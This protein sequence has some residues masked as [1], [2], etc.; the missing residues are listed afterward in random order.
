MTR[1]LLSLLVRKL[2]V[3]SLVPTRNRLV[4]ALT[5]IRKVPRT[6]LFTLAPTVMVLVP[7]VRPIVLVKVT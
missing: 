4:N 1:E 7:T 3:N 2:L 5:R 6:E